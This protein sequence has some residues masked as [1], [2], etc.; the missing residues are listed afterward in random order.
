M[1]QVWEFLQGLRQQQ[2]VTQMA[3]ELVTEKEVLW[4]L[5]AQVAQMKLTWSEQVE[6][7]VVI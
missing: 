5:V 7:E 3:L 2:L 1:E 6:V 4:E